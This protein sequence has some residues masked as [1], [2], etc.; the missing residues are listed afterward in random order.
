MSAGPSVRVLRPSSVRPLYHK[1]SRSL[2]IDLPHHSIGRR[3][4]DTQSRKSC[5]NQRRAVSTTSRAQQDDPSPDVASHDADAALDRELLAIQDAAIAELEEKLGMS[6]QQAIEEDILASHIEDSGVGVDDA[7]NEEAIEQDEEDPFDSMREA[8]ASLESIARE[9][10]N[11]FGDVL[12]EDI[13]TNEER[14]V[15]VRHYGEPL[16][17]LDEDQLAEIAA[18]EEQSE[19]Q[20]K[21][22]DIQGEPIRY[23]LENETEIQQ[24]MKRQQ[25]DSHTISVNSQPN[26]D[27]VAAL[28]DGQVLDEV[29]RGDDFEYDDEPANDTRAHPLTR[30][31]KSGTYP[32][33]VFMPRS[34]FL[35]PVEGVLSNFSNKQLKE[36]SERT[37]GGPGLPDSPLTPRSGRSRPQVPLP[38]DVS[39]QVMGQ[40]EANAFMAVVMPPMYAS[41][42]ATLTETRKRL[43]TTWL[44]SLLAKPGGPRILDVGS[45]GVGVVAW[46]EIV[47][48]HWDSLHSSDSKGTT[49]PPPSKTVVLTASDTL[50][51]RAAAMLENTTFIPRLPDYVNT[52]GMPTLE[53]DRP[54][55]QRKQFDVII[56]S[57][58]LFA[59]KEDWER[60]QHVQNLWSMLSDE[61]GILIIIEKGIPCGF[62][63]V[64]GA[65]HL[66]LERYIA[67]P[68]GQETHYTRN[69][70]LDAQ[71]TDISRQKG[72]I[73]A[74]CTNHDRC[75]LYR[76]MGLSKGRRDICGFQQRY[77]RPAFL[78]RIIG[79]RDRNHDDV[80]FS[81]IS[82]MKGEDLRTRDF[83]TLEHLGD[84][85]SA[86]QHHDLSVLAQQSRAV[87]ST[88]KAGFEDTVAFTASSADD[89]DAELDDVDEFLSNKKH[90][91][92]PPL[93][94]EAE[95]NVL[96]PP[97]SHLL[98]RQI[99]NPLKRRG[100]VTL[101]VCTPNATLERW[102]IPRSFSRQAYRDARKSRWGDLWAL[103]AKTTV[104]RNIKVGVSEMELNSGMGKGRNGAIGKKGKVERQMR[105]QLEFEARMREEEEVEERELQSMLDEQELER[106]ED[107]NDD[108]WMIDMDTLSPKTKT[109][110]R[111][112]REML[113]EPP[114]S[115][116]SAAT[117][118]SSRSR[119][120]TRERNQPAAEFRTVKQSSTPI[121]SDR[122]PRFGDVDPLIEWSD[123]FKREAQNERLRGQAGSGKKNNLAG[124]IGRRSTSKAARKLDKTKARAMR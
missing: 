81:Y 108:K 120:P 78:Q 12:P 44:N 57:H 22:Y 83:Q 39:Q 48:A 101:D 61:G 14:K 59:L 1:L 43:G 47:Q 6:L 119:G 69:N 2:L 34:A 76:S 116:S 37:F 94:I 92:I 32:K 42:M 111:S 98:P 51:H 4:N 16:D 85:L 62:E 80:D 65:R 33:T 29:N 27:E 112:S 49:T 95:S 104:P 118:A 46:R 60:K 26:P 45:G 75:P 54:P 82:V 19:P 68:S 38:I 84:P 91:S 77:I 67:T 110:E 13:L 96:V 10:R 100:H 23:R 9:A 107:D 87:S 86:P 117:T 66:L 99:M 73:V 3:I 93:S 88:I 106:D 17:E 123:S 24:D 70:E 21:L 72:M 74:P 90:K 31:G 122:A 56:A 40:M 64:A 50:R 114:A 105:R 35:E 58:S 115:K 52:R 53:D 30:I 109:K 63:A 124:T 28:L 55:Q 89:Y 79:A 25:S 113:Q 11:I 5:L 71:S 121:S 8:G 36:L 102:T 7:Q 18:G 103:G 15:Y 41:I 97:P 20:N